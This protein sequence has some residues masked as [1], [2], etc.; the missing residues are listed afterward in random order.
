[1]RFGFVNGVNNEETSC[2][3]AQVSRLAASGVEVVVTRGSA[4][5][6]PNNAA[7]R[8]AYYPARVFSAISTRL[9]SELR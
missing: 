8:P 7:N 1:M 3:P 9:L 2:S 6:V 4:Y 5:S